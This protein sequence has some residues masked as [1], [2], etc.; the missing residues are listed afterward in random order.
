MHNQLL[1]I[2][3][4][5]TSVSYSTPTTWN[6]LLLLPIL[7]LPMLVGGSYRPALCVSVWLLQK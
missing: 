6:R 7:P 4:G 3:F 2:K 1:L 5:K